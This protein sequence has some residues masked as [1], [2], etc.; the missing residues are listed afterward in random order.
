MAGNNGKQSELQIYGSVDYEFSQSFLPWEL[1]DYL[2]VVQGRIRATVEGNGEITEDGTE[3]GKLELWSVRFSSVVNDR[4][5]MFDVLDAHSDILADICVN[6][7]EDGSD[8]FLPELEIEPSAESLLYLRSIE[9]DPKYRDTSVVVDALESAI[10]TFC[11]SGVVVTDNEDLELRSKEVF[12][13]NLAVLP[14]TGFLYR[15][16]CAVNPHRK[17]YG[18]G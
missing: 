7:F 3:V 10:E 5:G 12:L 15:D 1:E 11:P 18:Q 16:T 13:L 8:E 2:I 14:N 4:E 9:V 6:L 17:K